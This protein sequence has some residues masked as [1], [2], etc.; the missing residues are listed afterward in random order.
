ME[1]A[2]TPAVSPNL[3]KEQTAPKPLTIRRRMH[4]N[5]L[6]QRYEAT[7]WMFLKA[8]VHGKKHKKSKCVK[9]FPNLLAGNVK[10]NL[11]KE[12]RW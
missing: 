1:A 4:V 8:E 11:E 12:S 9:H 7:Q 2:A 5:T 3:A 6:S 10:D